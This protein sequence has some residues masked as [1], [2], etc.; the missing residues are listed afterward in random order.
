MGEW[1]GSV[2]H[3]VYPDVVSN[4]RGGSRSFPVTGRSTDLRPLVSA[5]KELG[6]LWAERQGKEGWRHAAVAGFTSGGDHMTLSA[7]SH[8]RWEIR[9]GTGGREDSNPRIPVG[10]AEK[11]F[12][13]HLWSL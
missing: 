12:V 5:L 13:V 9:S 8:C 10:V 1:Y 3:L 7:A 4:G 6:A 11:G 2:G